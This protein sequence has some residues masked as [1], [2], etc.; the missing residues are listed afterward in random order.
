MPQRARNSRSHRSFVEGARLVEVHR[1]GDSRTITPMRREGKAFFQ[2]E[3]ATA[4][5]APS[6]SD[7]GAAVKDALRQCD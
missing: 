1:R 6:A 4:L 7:L 2:K 5:E 3:V